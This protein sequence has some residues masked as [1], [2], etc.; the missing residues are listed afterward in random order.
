MAASTPIPEFQ[1]FIR[2]AETL[3]KK[4]VS[5]YNFWRELALLTQENIG[6]AT[7]DH[8]REI[9]KGFPE[10][11]FGEGKTLAQLEKIIPRLWS[12]SGKILITRLDGVIALALQKRHP[13]LKWNP[14]ARCLHFPARPEIQY[15]RGKILVLAAGT[16]DLPVAEEAALTAA[17]LGCRV[18]ILADM[19]VAGLSRLLARLPELQRATVIIAAAGMEAAL[20]GVVAGLVKKPVI[21]L[22]TSVG[23]G[24]GAKGY[25]ALLAT[26]NSCSPGLLSVNIDNGFGAGYAA[27][28]IIWAVN[29]VK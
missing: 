15:R 21:A 3:K 17:L 25:A 9:R 4:R 18:K 24:T 7:L 28:Q 16:V 12:R 8:G 26:L 6:F 2:L 14:T 5:L 19:G 29:G 10:V 23:Y 1:K 27:A 22:P 11:V 20:P 13:K